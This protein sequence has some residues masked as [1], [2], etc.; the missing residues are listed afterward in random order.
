MQYIIIKS[1]SVNHFIKDT[2]SVVKSRLKG[3]RLTVAVMGLLSRK[4]GNRQ[5][6]LLSRLSHAQG[7]EKRYLFPMEKK[8]PLNSE[9]PPTLSCELQ[10]QVHPDQL[11]APHSYPL[12]TPKS[13][14]H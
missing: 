6:S 9:L 2:Q 7:T 8:K 10:L 11:L 1:I 13:A 3:R 14:T 5:T 12:S 4:A